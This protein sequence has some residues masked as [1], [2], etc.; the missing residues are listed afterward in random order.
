MTGSLSAPQA[1]DHLVDASGESRDVV[2]FDG[3]EHPYA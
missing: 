3:R 1:F 2:G